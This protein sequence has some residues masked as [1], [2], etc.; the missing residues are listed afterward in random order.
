MSI[1]NIKKFLESEAIQYKFQ[2][3]DDEI[4]I[5]NIKGKSNLN[6]VVIRSKSNSFKIDEDLFYYLDNQG[7]P[8]SFLL[9]NITDACLYYLKYK[10]ISNWLKD[11]FERSQKYEIYFGKIVFDY[12]VQINELKMKLNKEIA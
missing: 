12:K 6:L 7:T 4:D 9:E 2:E 3:Y 8:Y 10:M 5:F 11:S 1:I